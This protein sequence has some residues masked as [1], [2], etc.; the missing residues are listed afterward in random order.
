VT[1]RASLWMHHLA[2]L[3]PYAADLFPAGLV[4]LPCL[5]PRTACGHTASTRAVE[6]PGNMDQAKPSGSMLCTGVAAAL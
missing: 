6:T 5:R 1:A 2:A 4:Q 3:V